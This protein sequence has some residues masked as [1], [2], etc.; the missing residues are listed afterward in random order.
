MKRRGVPSYILKF[1]KFWYLNQQYAV[2][3][4]SVF[5]DWFNVT[6]GVR[7][8]GC[9]SPL[10]FN[11]YIDDLLKSAQK[12]NVGC[13]IN[14]IKINCIAYADD[15]VL[16]APSQKGLQRLIDVINNEASSLKI[17]FNVKK[18]AV[19]IFPPRDKS[20]H[21]PNYNVMFYLQ[22]EMLKIVNEFKYL[23]HIITSSLQDDQDSDRA[24]RSLYK[25]G[26]MLVSKFGKTSDLVKRRLFN[27]YCLPLF[28]CELWNNFRVQSSLVRI[29]QAY[30]SSVKRLWN[31]SK[32]DSNRLACI[33]QKLLTFEL[34]L[35]HRKLC[36]LRH[37]QSSAN[38]LIQNCNVWDLSSKFSVDIL[39]TYKR[40][41]LEAFIANDTTAATFSKYIRLFFSGYLYRDVIA[42]H[43]RRGIG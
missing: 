19:M 5:S 35:C 37:L 27:A 20:L 30:H 7:Q 9:L 15:I 21:I 12:V 25:C 16:I 10:L 38:S 18:S 42:N 32:F 4:G 33:D 23:G 1:L 34:Q 29:G 22:D 28:G 39:S 31:I 26:N 13:F 11:V 2:K 24:M 17:Q 3:W 8:G 14:G 40:Y 41:N 36:Y 6:N 43:P